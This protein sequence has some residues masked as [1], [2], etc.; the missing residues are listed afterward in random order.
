MNQNQELN[1]QIIVSILNLTQENKI[2]WNTGD[3]INY[4]T[5]LTD[6]GIPLIFYSEYN[7]IFLKLI[8]DI[9]DN[10]NPTF[11]LVILNQNTNESYTEIPY[12]KISENIQPVHQSLNDILLNQSV[13]PELTLNDLLAALYNIIVKPYNESKTQKLNELHNNLIQ[14]KQEIL[15]ILQ[16]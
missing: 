4:P 11:Q 8:S 6:D 13:I 15:N 10:Q 9:Y 16:T 12:I 14:S 5:R 3:N 2:S 7:N 1:I